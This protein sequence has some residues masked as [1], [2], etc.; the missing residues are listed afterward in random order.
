MTALLAPRAPRETSKK[1]ALT[2]IGKPNRPLSTIPFVLFLA[3][4]LA[5]GMVGMLILS[6][7]LQ[8]QAFDVQSKQREAN[9]LA[10]KVSSLQTQVAQA[11]SMDS[12]AADA[13]KLGM[14]PNPYT[15]PLRLSD[16][17]VLGKA[18][19]VSG[20]EMPTLDYSQGDQTVRATG[21]RQ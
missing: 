9:V 2:A 19:E 20:D 11:R 17:K 15:V 5:V 10:S 7:T 8:N 1:P 13:Q 14:R 21:T 6:T 18:R 4:M 12:L 3:G 16:G